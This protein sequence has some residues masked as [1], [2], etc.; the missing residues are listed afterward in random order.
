MGD[1]T[2]S[3]RSRLLKVTRSKLLLTKANV[4]LQCFSLIVSVF[5]SF[6]LLFVLGLN[7]CGEILSGCRKFTV[8]PR[9]LHPESAEKLLLKTNWCFYSSYLYCCMK[10][11]FLDLQTFLFIKH[12]RKPLISKSYNRVIWIIH[13]FPVGSFLLLLKMTR[14]WRQGEK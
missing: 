4:Q 2:Q 8:P 14:K 12:Y 3:N 11:H 10:C 13:I 5:I 1:D 9:G 6:Q 7:F